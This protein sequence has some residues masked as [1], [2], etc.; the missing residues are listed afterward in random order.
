MAILDQSARPNFL[1]ASVLLIGLAWTLPFLQPWHRFPLTAFYSEWLAFALGLA[2]ALALLHRK[3]W[4]DAAPPVVAI[5]PVGLIVVLGLQAALGRMPYEEQALTATLYLLWASLLMVLGQVIRRELGM[6]RV[7]TTL[8]W[9]LLA[10]G[11]LNALIG[12]V[13]HY[14]VSTPFNF[15]VAR[16]A[17]PMIYGNLGQPNHYAACVTLSLASAAYLYSR[18]SLQAA[19]ATA[20]A[21]LF[22]VVLALAGSRSPWLYLGTFIVL[23]LLLHRLQR[24]DAGRRLAVFACWL[25]PGFIAAQWLVTLPFMVPEEGPQM[26]TSAE[27]LFQMASGI[28]PRLQLWS[29]AW[30]M[31]LSAPFLGAGFGQFTWHHFLHQAATGATAAPGVYNHSHNVVMQLLAETGAL[32]ASVIVGA[33]LLWL[34]DLRRARFGLETWWLLALLCVI[35]IHS[36]LEYPLWYAYFLGVAALLLGLG[37][38]RVFVLRLAGAARAVVGLGIIAGWLNLIG[39]LSPYREFERLVFSPEQRSPPAA[40][41]QDFARALANAHREP[42]LVPY[43]ELAVAYG[44]TPSKEKLAEKLELTTRAMHF[45]PVDVVVYRQALLLALAGRGEAARAQLERSLR[46]Y[47][48]ERAAVVAELENLARRY[49]VE[50]TPLLELA[51]SNF[52]ERRVSQEGK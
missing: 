47:P 28:E 29:E 17:W 32:G 1:R 51:T 34:T 21:A 19:R 13:Q 43:V 2:A 26:V 7:A 44:I 49:P 16:K 12:L 8:A 3:S 14:H 46:V 40:E 38:E 22:L 48:K 18:G 9:F 4:Q 33:V 35:G 10:G 42:L 11:L 39:V 50:L 27:R 30:D 52:A 5:A 25:L 15:L 45:A 31:F 24:D 36:L 6:A 23:A 37:A 20:C 41:E